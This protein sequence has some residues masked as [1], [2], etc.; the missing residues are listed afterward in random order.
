MFE[1]E[2][3]MQL[4]VAAERFVMLF[5]EY[6]P[7]SIYPMLVTYAVFLR[8]APGVMGIQSHLLE[9]CW[10]EQARTIML[11]D[12]QIDLYILAKRSAPPMVD[13]PLWN[14]EMEHL[15]CKWLF[16]K[17]DN[18]RLGQLLGYV[19]VTTWNIDVTEREWWKRQK[20]RKREIVTEPAIR[21]WDERFID[22]D[23]LI[24]ALV[25]SSIKGTTNW[26]HINQGLGW[27]IQTTRVALVLAILIHIGALRPAG[28]WFENHIL[29]DIGKSFL[30]KLSLIRLN[31]KEIKHIL[32]EAYVCNIPALD[33]GWAKE[34]SFIQLEEKIVYV[35]NEMSSTIEPE[36]GVDLDSFY[37]TSQKYKIDEMLDEFMD[38]E[39]EVD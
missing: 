38:E 1:H 15:W 39:D 30:K 27:R 11:N 20:E 31:Q 23:S 33:L 6:S 8:L 7:S 22:S 17:L 28:K 12:K 16:E 18:E 9:M 29:T 36:E 32:E 35:K 37:R 21:R 5:P 19:D 3:P 4:K 34:F 26:M 24:T 13:Y 25:I 2:G 14:A 10:V